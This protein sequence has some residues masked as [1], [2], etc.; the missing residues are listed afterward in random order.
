MTIRRCL[1]AAA[2]TIV[3]GACGGSAPSEP[4]PSQQ[5]VSD[6]LQRLSQDAIQQGYLEQGLILG[7]AALVSKFGVEPSVVAIKVGDASLRYRGFVAVM[8]LPARDAMPAFQVRSFIGWTGE[9]DATKVLLV[10]SGAEAASIVALPVPGPG[11][12]AM[13]DIRSSAVAMYM[14]G[15]KG[16]RWAGSSG[17]VRL[18]EDSRGGPCPQAPTGMTC[19]TGAYAVVLDGQLQM[20]AAA[21]RSVTTPFSIQRTVVNAVVLGM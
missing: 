4:A 19:F 13:P 20:A 17:S 12:G 9:G 21:D 1:S 8:T 11:A 2:L 7:Q 14:D 6:V 3:V 5:S 10:G 16:A 18:V 15:I